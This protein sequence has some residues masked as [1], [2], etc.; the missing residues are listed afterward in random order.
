MVG[1]IEEERVNRPDGGR[2]GYWRVTPLGERFVKQGV[3]L[4]TYALIYDGRV[5]GLEGPPLYIHQTLSK[6]F[7]Y[8]EL[9]A[10]V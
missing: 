8:N 1:L 5:L 3:A 10:G 6:K 7:N 9:M 4:P 2:A